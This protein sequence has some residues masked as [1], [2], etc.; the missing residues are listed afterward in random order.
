MVGKTFTHDKA[1]LE[2]HPVRGQTSS[3]VGRMV[4]AVFCGG[5]FGALL[6]SIVAP[7]LLPAMALGGGMIFGAG[8]VALFLFKPAPPDEYASGFARTEEEVR[9]AL[10]EIKAREK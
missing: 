6:S 2:A 3:V 1:S 9:Q 8:V 7:A 10:A 5:I 4:L